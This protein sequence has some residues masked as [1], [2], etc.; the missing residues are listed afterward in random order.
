MTP[1]S[2]AANVVRGQYFAG[3]VNGEH[4]EGY[5]QEERVSPEANEE[6]YTALKLFIDNWR[7]SGVPFYLRTGKNLPLRASEVRVQFR[8]TPNVLFAAQGHLDL[9]ATRSRFAYSRTRA[10]S[11]ASTA[12]CRVCLLYTSPSPR[13]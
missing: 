9:H 11:S 12:R 3:T 7:W 8:P 6:T 2:V 1:E 4:R 10:F 13:D 5:R